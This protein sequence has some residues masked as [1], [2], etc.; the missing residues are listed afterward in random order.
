M[1]GDDFAS[2][3][4]TPFEVPNGTV[5]LGVEAHGEFVLG[6]SGELKAVTYIVDSNRSFER[7]LAGA[8][9]DVRSVTFRVV[10]PL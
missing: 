5:N 4:T 3:V 7:I 8:K 1:H 9:E 6:L 10:M 2:G